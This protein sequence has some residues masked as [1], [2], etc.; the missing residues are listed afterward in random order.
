MGQVHRDCQRTERAVW[1]S[2]L[3]LSTQNLFGFSC[4]RKERD[5]KEWVANLSRFNRGEPVPDDFL[6]DVLWARDWDDDLL[7][8]LPH[9]FQACGFLVVSDT[10]A[11]LLRGLT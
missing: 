3:L 10:L 1:A 11:N 5:S 6:P 4:A 2:D 9:L 7:E 8:R